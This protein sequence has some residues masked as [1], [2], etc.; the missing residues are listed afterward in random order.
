[1]SVIIILKTK[2]CP[3]NMNHFI[4]FST[5]IGF[6]LHLN[7]SAFS[8]FPFSEYI[9]QY[10]FHAYHNFMTL[11]FLFPTSSSLLLPRLAH[12]YFCSKAGKICT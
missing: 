6:T 4:H 5:L 3:T 2:T 1:M 8:L 11:F 9:S 7:L 12:L 10:S